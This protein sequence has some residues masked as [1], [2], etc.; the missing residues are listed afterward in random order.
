[1]DNILSRLEQNFFHFVRE[2]ADCELLCER[3]RRSLC[4]M[5]DF[6]PHKAFLAVQGTPPKGYATVRDVYRWL[7]DQPHQSPRLFLEDVAAFVLPF[8][9]RGDDGREEL[10]YEGFMR[11]VNP[12]ENAAVKSVAIC[13]SGLAGPHSFA[14]Y[15]YRR[16]APKGLLSQE[17]NY[18][19]CRLFSFEMESGRQLQIHRRL[20]E[21]HGI[22]AVEAFRVLSS[23]KVAPSNVA[24]VA[25]SE[26]RVLLVHRLRELTAKQCDAFCRRAMVSGTGGL[27]FQDM[28]KLL[29]PPC[30]SYIDMD[31]EV[32]RQESGR[33]LPPHLVSFLEQEA[34]IKPLKKPPPT[35][36][37]LP[38]T[39]QVQKA[40]LC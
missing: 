30:E 21:E 2:V 33:N 40:Q 22:T 24:Y 27:T 31:P 9:A 6:T 19:M 38:L 4:E 7:L 25:K 34:L 1:M 23:V 36:R 39:S 13:R 15:T 5:S 37:L 10:R 8:C 26:L 3:L 11:I 28:E 12:R 17:T 14:S 29:H 35:L 32:A 20:L 18:R 16:D